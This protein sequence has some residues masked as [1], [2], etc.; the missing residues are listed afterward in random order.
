MLNY[1]GIKCP[2]CGVPF[3]ENDD[4]VVCPECGAPYHRECYQQKGSCIFEELHREGGEW[5]PPA[6]P[7]PAAPAPSAE[8][9]DRECP[10]CGTLNN[11]SARFCSVCG[12]ALRSPQSQ[13]NRP[14]VPTSPG[15]S[16][17]R[18]NPYEA[19]PSF[20]YDPMGGVNPAEPLD[21]GVTYGDASKLV[22]QNTNYYMPVFRYIR[23][24]G[25]NKFNF[26][27]FLFSGG[28]L[29]YRKQYKPGIIV[30]AMVFALFVAYQ[31]T[32]WLVAWPAMASA[33]AAAGLDLSLEA[34]AGLTEQQILAIS[35]NIALNPSMAFRFF[36]PYLCLIAILVIMLAVGVRGN[37]MYLGHC[38]RTVRELKL[39]SQDD[40]EM[41]LSNKGGTNTPVTI[42]VAACFIIVQNLLPMLLI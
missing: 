20:Y 12:R 8:I 6:P 34:V 16:R 24:T 37:R 30:T 25:R 23:Q 26:S 15:E 3:T 10:N 40:P 5:N 7:A 31:L 28:W 36:L 19:A 11:H 42:C 22:R 32:Y 33:A 13:P 18:R 21:D 14:T 9:K 39:F 35:Q 29:L 1:K 4:I 27:A 41:T 38:C 17:Y 2:V